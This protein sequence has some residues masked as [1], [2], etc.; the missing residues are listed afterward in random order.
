MRHAWVF[1]RV[2]SPLRCVLD[3]VFCYST[4]YFS[5]CCDN[6]GDLGSGGESPGMSAISNERVQFRVFNV[7]VATDKNSATKSCLSFFCPP[8]FCHNLCCRQS[9]RQKNWGQK[10]T[11]EQRA[12]AFPSRDSGPTNRRNPLLSVSPK[13]DDIPSG[14]RRGEPECSLR[15]SG[16][17]KV[18]PL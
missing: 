5:I 12:V 11:F 3:A 16:K 18:K 8:F 10:N 1:A 15:S 2:C 13:S 9:C 7:R 17:S 14:P 4:I 6:F